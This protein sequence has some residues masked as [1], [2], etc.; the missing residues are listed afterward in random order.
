MSAISVQQGPGHPETIII[1]SKFNALGVIT[2]PDAAGTAGGFLPGGK[3][4]LLKKAG[5]IGIDQ[6]GPRLPRAGSDYK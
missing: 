2:E 6:G 4:F 5:F 3:N 1:S